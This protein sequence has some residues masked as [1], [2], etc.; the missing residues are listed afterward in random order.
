[1]VYYTAPGLSLVACLT[2]T[3]IRLELITDMVNSAGNAPTDTTNVTEPLVGEKSVETDESEPKYPYA[4]VR[5]LFAL[6]RQNTKSNRTLYI[7]PYCIHLFH[8]NKN[9]YQN[10]PA[11]C[12]FINS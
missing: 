2:I 7:S 5:N 8:N 4:L 10:N 3:G 11:S 9:S 1:M 6:I 12:K